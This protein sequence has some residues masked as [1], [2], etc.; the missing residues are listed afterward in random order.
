MSSSIVEYGEYKVQ[1]RKTEEEQVEYLDKL[2]EWMAQGRTIAAFC[3]EHSIGRGALDKW[4]LKS[5]EETRERL[6]RARDLG[7]DALAEETLEIAD[8]EPERGVDGRIDQGDVADRKLKIWT[9][10]QLISKWSPKK[11][12][13]RQQVEYSGGVVHKMEQIRIGDVPLMIDV[14][15][16]VSED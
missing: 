7:C 2:C 6:A 12:G 1:V 8:K 3:R 10:Q 14:G 16:A 15:S 5:P 4:V 13:D 9:R 11:Y